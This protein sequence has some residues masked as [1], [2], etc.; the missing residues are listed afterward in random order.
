MRDRL[1]TLGIVGA[2][3]IPL[4]IINPTLGVAGLVLMVVGVMIGVAT[5]EE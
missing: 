2:M 5:E 3:S 1:I 4:I